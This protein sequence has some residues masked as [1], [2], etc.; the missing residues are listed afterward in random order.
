MLVPNYHG[1]FGYGDAFLHSLCGH[2]GE[3]EVKDVMDAVMS[4]SQR[5]HR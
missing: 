4:P 1:S 3:I 5:I 2:I